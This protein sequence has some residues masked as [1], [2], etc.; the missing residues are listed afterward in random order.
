MGKSKKVC[1][2][3]PAYQ[4]EEHIGDIVRR[5]KNIKGIDEVVVVDDGSND[6]TSQIALR[7]G[8]KVLVHSSNQGKG[9]ALQTG[10]LYAL[11]NKF[12]GVIT[13]D[14]D[15]QHLPEEIPLF[16][17]EVEKKGSDVIVGSRMHNPEN[18]PFIRFWTNVITSFVTSILARKKVRDSQSGFRWI[19]S[20]VLKEVSL[21]SSQFAIESELLI[22]AGRKGFKITEIPI[23]TVYLSNSTKKSKIS[24]FKDTI[25]FILLILRSMKK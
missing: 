6:R 9:K 23:T 5:T 3:I 20:H 22:K 17:E 19:N 13:M 4:E 8:A 12:S 21:D 1:V 7:E 10:F 24:P 14:A 15:S 16:L 2:I 25:R 11:R 18:M